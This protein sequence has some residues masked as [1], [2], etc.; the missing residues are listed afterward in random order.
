MRRAKTVTLRLMERPPKEL[1]HLAM[2]GHKIFV[3]EF[4]PRESA[5]ALTAKI[6]GKRGR[7]YLIPRGIKGYFDVYDSKRNFKGTFH[8]TE[9]FNAE[10]IRYIKEYQFGK[11]KA[12]DEWYEKVW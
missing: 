6:A 9:L 11:K 1:Q 5:A 12:K 3:A 4:T 10:K 7:Y 8:K 2:S